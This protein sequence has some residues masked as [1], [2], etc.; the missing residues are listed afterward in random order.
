M[1]TDQN[2]PLPETNTLG[3]LCNHSGQILA[4]QTSLV[5]CLTAFLGWI[6]GDGLV[7]LWRGIM[8]YLRFL[9]GD[10]EFG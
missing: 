4:M 7:A 8:I 9:L 1:L 5:L 2:G 6:G 3:C 10:S